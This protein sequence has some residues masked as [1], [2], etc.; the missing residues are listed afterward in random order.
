MS[1]YNWVLALFLVFAAAF[2]CGCVGEDGAEEAVHGAEGVAAEA[3]GAAEEAVHGAEG[4]A[5][6]A[7]GAAE[8]TASGH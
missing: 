4:A 6:E 3:A 8:E 2:A 1:R 5:A 7:A